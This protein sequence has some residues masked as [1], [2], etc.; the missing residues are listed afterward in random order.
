[1]EERRTLRNVRI[2]VSATCIITLWAVV[3]LWV[4]SRMWVLLVFRDN[5]VRSIG[6]ASMP[7]DLNLLVHERRRNQQIGATWGFHAEPITND[8]KHP[9][10]QT[11]NRRS[12]A[13]GFLWIRTSSAV[14]VTVRYWFLAALSAA[15]AFAPWAPWSRRFS[16]RTLLAVTTFVAVVLGLAVAFR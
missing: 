3:V 10:H 4:S 12:L 9:L 15:C 5:G 6:I 14:Q 13:L 11:G 1:M 16:L 8:W 2:A 7:G